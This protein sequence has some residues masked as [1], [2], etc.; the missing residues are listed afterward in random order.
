[1]YESGAR[2]L[3]VKYKLIMGQHSQP[4]L[5]IVRI[6]TIVRCPRPFGLVARMGLGFRSGCKRRIEE[7]NRII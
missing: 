4:K 6:K 2:L 1:M 3:C 7:N 5:T